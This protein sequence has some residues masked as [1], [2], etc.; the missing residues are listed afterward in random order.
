M[1]AFHGTSLTEND[2]LDDSYIPVVL[3]L[4]SLVWSPI[5]ILS[6]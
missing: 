4:A 2:A 6:S 5:A 3:V 1:H